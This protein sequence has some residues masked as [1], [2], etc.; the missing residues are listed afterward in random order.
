MK[1]NPVY[2]IDF[3]P[4]GDHL[5]VTIPEIGVVLE[6]GPGETRREDVERIAMAAI[7]RYEHQQYKAAHEVKAS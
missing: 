2:T 4:V 7:S 5:K 1:N 3:E 6:T